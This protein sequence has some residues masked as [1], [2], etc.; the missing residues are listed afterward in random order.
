MLD[1]GDPALY[2]LIH[3]FQVNLAIGKA[4]AQK[5]ETALKGYAVAPFQT[6]V[7]IGKHAPTQEGDAG[8]RWIDDGALFVQFQA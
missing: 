2:G 8:G 6:L 3:L 1:V 7:V 4:G 5:F